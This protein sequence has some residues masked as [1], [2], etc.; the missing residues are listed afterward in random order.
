MGFLKLVLNP[1]AGEAQSGKT[2]NSFFIK[3][4]KR[5]FRVEMVPFDGATLPD[6]LRSCPRD[7]R[8]IIVAG[9]DGSLNEVVN[10][11]LRLEPPYPPL[12]VLPLGT[13][14]DFSGNILDSSFSMDMLLE[15]ISRQ[16]SRYVDIG[17]LNNRYFINVVGAGLLVDVAHKTSISLKQSIG[18]L[19]YYLEGALN[20]PTYKPFPLKFESSSRTEELDVDLC[21]VLNGKA[22][23]GLRNLCPKARLD[24]GKLDVLLI[25]KTGV[26]GLL[27]LVPRLLAGN[28]TTDPR[29]V[30]FQAQEFS[31]QAP[32]WV[33]T[34]LDGEPGPSFPLHF[35]VLQKKLQFISF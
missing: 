10:V 13:S 30:Y 28:H 29:V 15:A 25:R 26:P 31:I 6:A 32:S 27:S 2:M 12:A 22:A 11:L 3:A 34:D 24:D 33:E 1:S 4:A 20:L 8:A 17:A 9:G 23:G 7:T 5:G 21:L 16:E 18:M 19:A 14:N 35:S